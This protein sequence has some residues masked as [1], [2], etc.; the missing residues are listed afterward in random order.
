MLRLLACKKRFLKREDQTRGGG[1]QDKKERRRFV[2]N[3][4]CSALLNVSLRMLSGACQAAS[5]R[6]TLAYG[7]RPSFHLN[8]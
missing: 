1:G 7:T 3:G 2:S 6:Y 5:V 4:L 8:L